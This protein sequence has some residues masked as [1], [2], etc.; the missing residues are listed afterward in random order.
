MV[1]TFLAQRRVHD[2]RKRTQP[3]S[4]LASSKLHSPYHP[5]A[6][7]FSYFRYV[8]NISSYII[9]LWY[10]AL[11]QQCNKSPS[12]LLN[13]A[14]A[15]CLEPIFRRK[16]HLQLFSSLGKRSDFGLTS[17]TV[18]SLTTVNFQ[19]QRVSGLGPLSGSL[20]SKRKKKFT[21]LDLFSSSCKGRAPRN[22]RDPL[23]RAN[24]NPWIQGT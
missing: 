17:S 9:T 6:D 20:N 24:L 21:R 1:P 11:L 23:G 8:S 5:S 12:F 19:R 4:H 15:E 10:T 18:A 13:I 2:L 16:S 14:T 22:L 7:V 3:A